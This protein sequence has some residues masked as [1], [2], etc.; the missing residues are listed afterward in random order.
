M[1]MTFH[2]DYAL[3]ML[4]YAALR[5]DG[6][7]TVNDVAVTYGLSRNHL[8]KVAL[9]LRNLGL[10]ETIRGRSGG[11]RIAKAPAEINIGALVRATEEDFSLVECM[12]GV[13][14]T[15]AISPA[16]R[17]KGVFAEALAA[18]LAVLDTYTL[19]DIVRNRAV[20][21]PLLGISEAIA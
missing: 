12:Q 9:T 13:G 8:L 10:I 18:Y 6:V 5:P 16:C 17:L 7:C 4:I 19:A 21:K 3:R 1:R 14:G 11:I 15:C 2:T 20:L